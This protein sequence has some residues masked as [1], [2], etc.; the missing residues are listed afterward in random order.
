MSRC[1]Y[2]ICHRCGTGFANSVSAVRECRVLGA[3]AVLVTLLSPH[4]AQGGGMGE[5]GFSGG[6]GV[7][8]STPQF[9]TE[10]IICL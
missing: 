1:P 9:T 3:A 4:S 6:E 7:W 5:L 2:R 8:S 10:L